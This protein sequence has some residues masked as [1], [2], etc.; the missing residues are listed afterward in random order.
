VSNTEEN[1]FTWFHNS[2][3]TGDPACLCSVC[4]LP[5]CPDEDDEDDPDQVVLR[6][7]RRTRRGTLEARFHH[8]CQ[9]R[10][11]LKRMYSAHER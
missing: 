8:A 11:L 7:W 1:G 4:L 10:D 9:P 3:D 6:L 5:I 2:P